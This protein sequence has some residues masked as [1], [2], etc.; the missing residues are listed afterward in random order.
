MSGRRAHRSIWMAISRRVSGVHGGPDS[1]L[2]LAPSRTLHRIRLGLGS[3]FG[4]GVRYWD[5]AG[6]GRAGFARSALA[7]SGSRATSVGE[8]FE[9]REPAEVRLSSAFIDHTHAAAARCSTIPVVRYRFAASPCANSYVGETG[10]V[11]EGRVVD[12]LNIMT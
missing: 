1:V 8:E 12:G 5:G 10:Q 11:H 6:R 2:Q 3:R 4:N 7:R 9:R